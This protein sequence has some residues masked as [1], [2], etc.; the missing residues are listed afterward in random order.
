M[1]PITRSPRVLVVQPGTTILPAAPAAE[2]ILDAGATT[3][4]APGI[5]VL[6]LSAFGIEATPVLM[7][8]VDAAS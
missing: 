6:R 4:I 7:S 5:Y 1:R 2:L 3:N 8:I